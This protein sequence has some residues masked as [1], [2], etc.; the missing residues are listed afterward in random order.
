MKRKPGFFIFLLAIVLVVVGC[1][2]ANEDF[3]QGSWYT[4]SDHLDQVSGETYL[5]VQWTF[6]RG[7]F[8]YRACCF[9]IDASLTGRYRIL[10]SEGDEI[11]LE[12]FNVKGSETRIQPEIKLIINRDEDTLVVIGGGEYRRVLSIAH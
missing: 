9:N 7:T 3:I 8:A 5:E 11:T 6:D 2:D 4:R 12:L 1:T 10:E